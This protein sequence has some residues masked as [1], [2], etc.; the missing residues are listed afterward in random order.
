MYT[1]GFGLQLNARQSPGTGKTDKEQ[2]MN[3]FGKR[4][5][6]ATCLGFVVLQFLLYACKAEAGG[7]SACLCVSY[8]ATGFGYNN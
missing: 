5:S 8:G 1:T 6:T 4:V 3:V 7:Q 2:K